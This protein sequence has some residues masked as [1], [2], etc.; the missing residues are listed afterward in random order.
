M[1][2]TPAD[3]LKKVL[4]KIL[5]NRLG[6]VGTKALLLALFDRLPGWKTRNLVTHWLICKLEPWYKRWL[7]R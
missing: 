2:C 7:P 6:D 4:R 5:F 1:Q 3:T